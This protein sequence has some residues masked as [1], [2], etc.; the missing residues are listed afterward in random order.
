MWNAPPPGALHY[1]TAATQLW[2]VLPIADHDVSRAT[3]RIQALTPAEQ[4]AV[5]DVYFQPRLLLSTFAMLFDDF[6][7]AEHRLIEEGNEEERWRY[8]QRQIAKCRVRCH[9]IARHLSEHV[10]AVTRQEHPE[11]RR[12]ALLILKNLYGDENTAVPALG[13]TTTVTCRRL[14]GRHRQMGARLRRYSD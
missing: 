12:E 9:V 2:A 14:P 8:F 7:E 11:G 6:G 5:Q 4:Q 10:E 3:H 13:R 1:D